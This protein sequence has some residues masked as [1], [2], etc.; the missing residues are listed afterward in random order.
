M[1]NPANP[2]PSKPSKSS[3]SATHR[4]RWITL[5]AAGAALASV[6]AGA[7]PAS[8]RQNPA[9]APATARIGDQ[10][11]ALDEQKLAQLMTPDGVANGTM[12]RV[13]GSGVPGIHWTK[14]A[15]PVSQ[16]P[17][18]SFRIGSMTKLFTSTLVLQL[19]AE[20]RFTLDTPIRE[21]LPDTIPAHWAPI[22]IGQLLSHTSGLRAPC[23]DLRDGLGLTPEK[24]VAA[25]TADGCPAPEHPVTTQQYN[26]G[27]YFI[28]G[29]A[30]EKVTGRSYADELQR[31][32]T[33]PLG[34]RHTYLPRTGD[35]SM[36]SPSL[37]EPTPKEPWAW[38]EGGM[39]SNAPD[40]ERFMK[41]LL[42]G[43]LLPPA[44]QAQLFVMPKLAATSKELP[45]SQGGLAYSKLSDGTE[46][47]GKTG[48]MAQYSNGAFGTAG[49]RRIVTYS[50]LPTPEATKQDVIARVVGIVEAA[51]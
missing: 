7:L 47:W 30:I 42:G 20:G 44:Q 23:G 29:L 21:V 28:L 51:L 31:R 39:I 12:V 48:S 50:F 4:A 32:I 19:V 15:G 33:R 35:A 5:V 1:T 37:A 40:M 45:Y 16:D 34:L 10:R 43:R 25:W 3:N 11:Y 14:A 46:V 49:G 26:G 2:K 41:A 13:S 22:T 9:P 36:P 24:V 6:T 17:A 8:A 38:A 27:N 18:A